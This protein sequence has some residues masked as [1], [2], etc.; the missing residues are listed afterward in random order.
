[1]PVLVCSNICLTK[2]CVLE[3]ILVKLIFSVFP[4]VIVKIN[5]ETAIKTLKFNDIHLFSFVSE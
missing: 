1:M 3:I 4:S 5:F 2:P